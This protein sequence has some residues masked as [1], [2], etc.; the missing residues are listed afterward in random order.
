MKEGEGFPGLC[1]QERQTLVSLFARYQSE[2]PEND[3]VK[4]ISFNYIALQLNL[5]Q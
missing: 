2:V 3:F 1:L 5:D 4:G